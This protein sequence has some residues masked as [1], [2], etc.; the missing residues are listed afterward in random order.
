M[1]LTAR[2]LLRTVTVVAIAPLALVACGGSDTETAPT[3]S[4][5]AAEQTASEAPTTEETSEAPTA[6]ETSEPAAQE[7]APVEEY[8]SALREAVYATGEVTKGEIPA[9]L[10]EIYFG[11]IVDR[12]YDD[13]SVEAVNTLVETGSESGFSAEDQQI[14]E[15]SIQPCIDEMTSSAG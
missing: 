4:E 10:E 7:K 1:S 3:A 8:D 14:L 5:T 12:T 9:D 2:R 11:C 6:E 15:D 13:I